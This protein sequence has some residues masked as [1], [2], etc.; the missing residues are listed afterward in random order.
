MS[1]VGRGGGFSAPSPASASASRSAPSFAAQPPQSVRSVRRNGR[2]LEGGHAPM[3]GRRWR[4]ATIARGSG[5]VP[6][7]P[8]VFKTSGAA[9]GAARWVRLPRVPATEGSMSSDRPRP[10]S[11]E[12][13]LAAVRAAIADRTARRTRSTAVARDVVADE[14]ARLAAGEPATDARR[15]WRPTVVDRLD[16]LRDRRGERPDPGHQRDRRHPPHEP[17][18]RAVAGASPSRPRRGAGVGYSLL[19]FDREAGRRGPRFRVA[20]E[21]LIA[22]TGAE[23]ALV[24]INNAAALALAVGLAGRA[25]GRGLARRAGRD[26]RRR[27]DP[28]DRPAGRRPADRGRHDEPDARGRLRGAAG[29]RPGDGRPPR[30]SVELRAGRL[31]RGARRD[32]ARPARPRARRDRRR[33]PRQRRAAR[34]GGL[35]AGPRADAARA[36]GGR[37]GPRHV[38]RRQAGRRAAGRAHRRPG[39]PRSPGSGRTRWPA[40]SG[41][42]R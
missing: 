35:R 30:P 20:E 23:D 5:R 27:P 7:G 29:R 19:E 42:T 3:I 26:R 36:A 6:V 2:R 16:G 21:H 18:S 10:P 1:V 28:G 8:L 37:R 12:R 38:Q 22:L 24:T 31:R 14:R 25:R 33:R 34:D 15:V 13:L 11:V 32:R 40:R 39:R 4:R 17:R 41:P 9:L